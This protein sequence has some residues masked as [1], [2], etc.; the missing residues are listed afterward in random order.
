MAETPLEDGW[1]S[2]TAG[3]DSIV[4]DFIDSS[5]AYITGV[6][7]AVGAAVIDDG[8]VA[9][10]HHGA[11]F[12]FVNMVV[13]RR[14]IADAAW[15][16][17]LARIRDAFPAGAPFV[18]TAP[19]PT[20]DLTGAGF[21]RLGHPPF[22]VR[23]VGPAPDPVSIDGLEIATVTDPSTLA[24]FEQ[25]L[26]DAY[27]AGPAG[28]MFR[29]EILDVVGV[30]PWLATLDDEP[31]ATAA[32][33]HAGGVNG[34]EMVACHP[35]VRGRRIGEAITWAAT[36]TAPTHPGTLVASDAGRPVYTRMGFLPVTRFTLWVGA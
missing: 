11:P 16:D 26:I 14:P 12:P 30:T 19:F 4:R 21:S 22:M 29:P 6:G 20:P 34:V 9:G 27:P 17:R 7:N 3:G 24:A 15:P 2:T 1:Q 32:T 25:T 13:A 23:P 36:L 31:V 28:S 5:A 8:D 35:D 10:A 18:I 33:H